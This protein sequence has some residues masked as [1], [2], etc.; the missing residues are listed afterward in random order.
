MIT[1]D[2]VI[3]SKLMV[4]AIGIFFLFVTFGL[5]FALPT[6]IQYILTFKRVIKRGM[7]ILTVKLILN[8]LA[9]TGTVLTFLIVKGS[10]TELLIICYS[11]A[12]IVGS[13]FYRVRPKQIKGQTI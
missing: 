1:Y 8:M 7:S 9:I 11:S 12:L 5:F 4:D 10:M 3:S 2:A 13:L 6:F